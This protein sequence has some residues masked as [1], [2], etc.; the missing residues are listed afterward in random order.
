MPQN[1]EQHFRSVAPTYMRLLLTD[2]PMLGVEDAAAVFGN[3]GHESKGLTDDQEDKPVVKGSRGGLNWMQWTG[4]RRK[5]MEAY[6][7][8]NKLDP[9]SDIAAYKWLFLELK[10]AEKKA[11]P[12]LLKATTLEQKVIAFEKAFLRAGVKHYPSRQQWAT[13]AL[14]AFTDTI[15]QPAPA[16]APEPPTP[17]EEYEEPL[18]PPPTKATRPGWVGIAIIAVLS[19]AVG[20]CV[21]LFGQVA[22][23]E[24]VSLI[25]DVQLPRDR[26]FGLFG[27]GGGSLASEIA[28]QVALA[29]VAPLVSA[30]ATAVVGWIT[31]LWQRNLKADF[32]AKSAESLHKA[33][34]R[35]MLAAIDAFGARAKKSTLISTAADYAEQF[36]GGTI[37]RFGL[38][39]DSLE[40]LAVPHLAAAKAKTR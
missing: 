1:T 21:W 2:F 14:D 26:P 17:V 8:R 35:G 9:A 11:I 18:A 15:G 20:L 13:V 32:D 40:Q 10:G 28:L 23:G 29:F 30:A 33:L 39:R 5:A 36:N 27:A 25:G 37:K 3:A 12:A 19:I 22:T 6:C 31:F 4:P 34:E 7:A 24:E 16:P 38:T